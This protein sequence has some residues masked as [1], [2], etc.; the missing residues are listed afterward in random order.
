[1]AP[2]PPRIE[3]SSLGEAAVPTG[4]LAVGLRSP[5]EMSS[6]GEAPSRS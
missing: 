1:M 6:S 4:A 2:Y 5:L 3:F